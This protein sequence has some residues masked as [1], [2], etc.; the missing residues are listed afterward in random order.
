MIYLEFI[1]CYFFFLK[2][3]FLTTSAHIYVLPAAAVLLSRRGTTSLY[4]YRG[5]IPLVILPVQS[6]R[7]WCWRYLVHPE[8]QNHIPLGALPSSLFPPPA[9]S[10]S[11]S[12]VSR[13][14]SSWEEDLLW[15][16]RGM[17]CF[18]PRIVGMSTSRGHFPPSRPFCMAQ[19]I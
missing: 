6:L 12:P 3:R 15:H 9:G 1:L 7:S 17:M 8:R 10:C 18:F 19:W 11:L 14:S 2:R 4:I 5:L 13:S 16:R